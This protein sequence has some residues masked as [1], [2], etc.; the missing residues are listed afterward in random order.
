MLLINIFFILHCFVFINSQEPE[1]RFLAPV[2]INVCESCCEEAFSTS[3]DIE[4]CKDEGCNRPTGDSDGCTNNNVG[5]ET[6][7]DFLFMGKTRIDGQVQSCV[8][9]NIGGILETIS[10]VF[11]TDI[12]AEKI[13]YCGGDDNT[14]DFSCCDRFNRLDTVDSGFE[15]FSSGACVDACKTPESDCFEFSGTRDRFGCMLAKD[16]LT[17]TDPENSANLRGELL[18]CVGDGDSKTTQTV[19]TS[20]PTSF[21]IEPT[22][23]PSGEPTQSTPFPTN[24]PTQSPSV[25]PTLSPS[26]SPTLSPSI[27]PSSK[28]TFSPSQNPTTSEP[29]TSPEIGI[30]NNPTNS[31]TQNPTFSP[32]VQPTPLPTNI[33]STSP[34]SQ[35]TQKPT[36]KP[37]RSPL[38]DGQTHSPSITDTTN[39][40][41]EESTPIDIMIYVV[42]SLGLILVLL[43]C[44]F[45]ILLGQKNKRKR[46][47]TNRYGKVNGISSGST[48]KSNTITL[49]IEVP[50]GTNIDPSKPETLVKTLLT[51]IEVQSGDRGIGSSKPSVLSSSQENGKPVYHSGSSPQ[52]FFSERSS[53]T[54]SI[55][56]PP[57]LDIPST[58]YR[59]EVA[60]GILHSPSQNQPM[61]SVGPSVKSEQENSRPSFLSTEDRQNNIRAPFPDTLQLEKKYAN[62]SLDTLKPDF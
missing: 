56:P 13:E 8:Q 2:T 62:E 22:S 7:R 19:P 3:E 47:M 33:P 36:F 27:S 31:P 53:N 54:E 49:Q 34:S 57:G 12:S 18:E 16:L 44:C 10:L 40:P 42:G 28:P 45:G 35:P 6:G 17:S 46:Y 24:S 32:T 30:T 29:T 38:T 51:Q 58:E 15:D 59:R 21:P 55:P 1:D 23:L 52:S 5:C 14:A 39:T 25:S 48:G 9:T 26:L 4:N 11:P 50:E 20:T 61:R 43:L 41:E 37:T 60:A